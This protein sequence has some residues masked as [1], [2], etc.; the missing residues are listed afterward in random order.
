MEVADAQSPRTGTYSAVVIITTGW[1][2]SSTNPIYNHGTYTVIGKHHI[3]KYQ[4]TELFRLPTVLHDVVP[5]FCHAIQRFSAR[6]RGG[7]EQQHGSLGK[8]KDSISFEPRKRL[9]RCKWLAANTTG[10]ESNIFLPLW[11]PIIRSP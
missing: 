5:R 11:N 10:P 1:P 6:T 9:S 2:S 8:C 4:A 3:C 7:Q